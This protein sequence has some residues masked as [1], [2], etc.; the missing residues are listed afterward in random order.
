M[1][2]IRKPPARKLKEGKD[3]APRQRFFKKKVCRFCAEKINKIDYKDVDMLQKFVTEKGKIV[4]RRI[5]GNCSKHQRVVAEQIKRARFIALL[6][7]QA[8]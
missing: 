1:A 7:F 2:F 4:P 5:S 6:P 3:G 8:E